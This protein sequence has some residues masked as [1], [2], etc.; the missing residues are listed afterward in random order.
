MSAS[1]DSTSPATGPRI[2]F[3]TGGSGLR[4]LCGHLVRRTHRSVHL[5]TP[6]DSGGS[7]AVLREALGMPAVG[8]LRNRLLA[9]S[10]PTSSGEAALCDLLGHRLE[11]DASSDALRRELAAL[12]APAPAAVRGLMDTLLGAVPGDFD[13]RHASVG[14]LVLAGAWLEEDRHLGRA[15][16]RVEALLPVRGVV[17]PVTE[18]V[19]H[20]AA[21]MDDGSVVSGQ[22][23]ITQGEWNGRAR[24]DALFLTEALDDPRP[25]PAPADPAAV[26]LIAGADLI[27]Y[28]VGSFLTSLL[29]ALLP[30][31]IAGAVAHARVPKV[32]V[33]NPPGDP[34][35]GGLTVTDR[36]RALA[37]T[38]ASRGA[39]PGGTV[40]DAVLLDEGAPSSQRAELEAMGLRVVSAALRPSGRPTRYDDRAL[41]DALLAL[42][43]AP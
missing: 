39:P 4:G 28:P 16:E 23:R 21:R 33:P 35:E 2:L 42:P 6:F 3:F 26:A 22:H 24:V 18:A 17:R 11:A 13:L 38:L 7:S 32:Y 15:V 10:D 36:V 14:N 5:V 37:E 31:G 34:E 12:V 19:R 29:A 9:L 25:A 41:A 27:C 30:E 8:D 40:L 20:L 43:M 1:H